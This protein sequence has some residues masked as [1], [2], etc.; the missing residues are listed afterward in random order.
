[1]LNQSKATPVE[2]PVA[3]FG[4]W[5]SNVPQDVRFW[6]VAR[7]EVAK[8]PPLWRWLLIPASFAGND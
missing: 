6:Q 4:E 3:R 2:L 5:R 7:E 8:I 1:M